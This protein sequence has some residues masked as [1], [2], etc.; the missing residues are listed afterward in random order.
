MSFLNKIQVSEVLKW[1][2]PHLEIYTFF[3]FVAVV[4]GFEIF[5]ASDDYLVVVLFEEFREFCESGR[6]E[7]FVESE[8]RV[9]YE[10]GLV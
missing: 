2:E 4:D 9:R 6:I 10:K 7:D 8:L 5:R 3:R 1:A